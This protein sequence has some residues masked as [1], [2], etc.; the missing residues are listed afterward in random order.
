MGTQ[1]AQMKGLVCWACLAGTREFCSALAGLV[2]P[3][4]NIFL[5]PL[6]KPTQVPPIPAA[7]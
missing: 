3:V 4:Q 1:R 5:S 2:S 6:K 7:Q